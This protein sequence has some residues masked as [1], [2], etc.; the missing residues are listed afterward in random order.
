[1][2]NVISKKHNTKVQDER[3][4]YCEH[5]QIGDIAKLVFCE[6][7]SFGPVARM[8]YCEECAVAAQEEADNELEHC[9]DCGNEVKAKDGSEYRWFDFY[10]PQGD[11]PLFICNSCRGKDKHQARVAQD[12]R[13]YDA[14]F[15]DQDDWD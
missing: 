13:D 5:L 15:G 6:D 2:A 4:D 8:A 11:E 9:H 3:W 1:M 10:A 14:E 7:D 12:K